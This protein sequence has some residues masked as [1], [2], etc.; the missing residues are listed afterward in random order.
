MKITLIIKDENLLRA[1]S[2]QS[3]RVSL[4]IKYKTI[5]IHPVKKNTVNLMC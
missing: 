2:R 5:Q 1:F 4:S 3:V